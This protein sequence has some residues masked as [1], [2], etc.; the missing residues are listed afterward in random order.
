MQVIILTDKTFISLIILN[1]YVRHF[2][3]VDLIE[4]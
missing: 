1:S 2:P 4:N 3:S